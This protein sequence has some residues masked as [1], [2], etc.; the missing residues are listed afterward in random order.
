MGRQQ[1]GLLGH[2]NIREGPSGKP[3]S[4]QKYEINSTCEVKSNFLVLDSA[5]K[6]KRIVWEGTIFRMDA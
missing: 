4:L 2:A 6:F 5:A 3:R 1:E